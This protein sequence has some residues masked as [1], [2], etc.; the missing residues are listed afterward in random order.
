MV[1]ITDDLGGNVFGISDAEDGVV[2]QYWLVSSTGE[3]VRITAIDALAGS[4]T[5]ARAQMN[6]IQITL[7]AE[8]ELYL[9]ADMSL[10]PA[11]VSIGGVA[12]SLVISPTVIKYGETVCGV[13][14]TFEPTNAPKS[15]TLTETLANLRVS[16]AA[17]G[18]AMQF[19]SPDSLKI[20]ATSTRSIKIYVVVSSEIISSFD[21]PAG[22]TIQHGVGLPDNVTSVQLYAHVVTSN[23]AGSATITTLTE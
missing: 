6:S 17:I 7:D 20:T 10:V 12:G 22:K 4:W 19:N 16:P 18:T 9:L 1:T 11:A 8:H 3:I 14:G 2:G 21:V 5:L 15:R 23:E 13:A